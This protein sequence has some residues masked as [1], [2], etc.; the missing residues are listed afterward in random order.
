MRIT[1]GGPLK[2][3]YVR[4]VGAQALPEARVEGGSF[5][6]YPTCWHVGASRCGRM[7]SRIW[8]EGVAAVDIGPWFEK[9]ANL[10]G[11]DDMLVLMPSCAF[12]SKVKALCSMSNKPPI[13]GLI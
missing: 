1:S 9:K 6:K 12:T 3:L 10:G 11:L 4:C 8:F 2:W 5:A 13:S 7:V